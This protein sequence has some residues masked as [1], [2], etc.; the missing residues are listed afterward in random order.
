MAIALDCRWLTSTEIFLYQGFPVTEDLANP[1]AGTR[2][3]CTSFC[4]PS[5]AQEVR[6]RT[7]SGPQAGY[8]MNAAVCMSLYLYIMLWTRRIDE[9]AYV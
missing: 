1:P 2:H 9:V 4:G 7:H 5:L 8:S 6:T 3:R